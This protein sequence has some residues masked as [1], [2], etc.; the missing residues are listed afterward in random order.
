V[1]QVNPIYQRQK[2]IMDRYE[3]FMNTATVREALDRGNLVGQI[4]LC[5]N[6]L[7]QPEMSEGELYPWPWDE[8]HELY[9]VLYRQ[10]HR[11]LFPEESRRVTG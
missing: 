3:Q 9:C 7:G 10:L 1:G 4:T 6:L 11:R 2:E 8:L 5:Q